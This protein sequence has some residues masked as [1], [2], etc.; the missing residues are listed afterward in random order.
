MY[1]PMSWLYSELYKPFVK[2]GQGP[3]PGFGPVAN[4]SEN[5]GQLRKDSWRGKQPSKDALRM[6]QSS[7]AIPACCQC[8]L[9][10]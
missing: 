5:S 1:L 4:G 6:I 7:Q 2:E 8:N 10:S 3:P 9:L